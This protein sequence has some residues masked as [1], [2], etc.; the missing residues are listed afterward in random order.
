MRIVV[1]GASG[2]LGSILMEI[3]KAEHETSGTCFMR[4]VEGL[5]PLDLLD[6]KAVHDFFDSVN[7]DVVI[8][9][10]ALTNVDE[11]QRSPEQAYKINVLT[12]KNVLKGIRNARLVYISTDQVYD[13]VSMS[14]VDDAVP[15]N[16]YALTK[17]HAEDVALMAPGS[18]V[19]RTNFFGT[20]SFKT[21]YF[22]WLI[23][24]LRSGRRFNAFNDVLFS[25]LFI[26]DF[27]EMLSKCIREGIEGIYNLGA[28]ETLSKADFAFKVAEV[29][30]YSGDLIN[31]VSIET[32]NLNAPRPK[33]MSMDS[34][35]IEKA[36]GVKL[37]SV[38]DG[39]K[40]LHSALSEGNNAI[41][42]NS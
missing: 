23:E 35:R 10:V 38:H 16:T 12:T 15:V 24:N 30:G 4:K 28:S 34:T 3:L 20:C 13:G 1:T 2:F 26:G 31:S 18:L 14:R 21:T 39:I 25:P 8:H 27:S 17:L 42:T 36:L 29:F 41:V 22:D 9:T 19:L 7:P 6:Q 33:N 32:A 5:V 11:C 40:A 37:P